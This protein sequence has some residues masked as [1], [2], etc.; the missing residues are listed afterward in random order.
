MQFDESQG[1]WDGDEYNGWTFHPY[2]S[3]SENSSSNSLVST[4]FPQ[5]SDVM[6]NN[7][8][9]E[10]FNNRNLYIWIS[11]SQPRNKETGEICFDITYYPGTNKEN[12]SRVQITKLI[13]LS[14]NTVKYEE[15]ANAI[16]D[17]INVA[18]EYPHINRKC[19]CCNKR[20]IKSYVVCKSCRPTYFEVIYA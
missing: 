17:W 20:A 6:S 2:T 13:D 18:K 1:E 19:L 15:I 14:D 9:T 12:T 11:R 10:T 4:N 16:N 8:S 5:Y 7:Q 3:I